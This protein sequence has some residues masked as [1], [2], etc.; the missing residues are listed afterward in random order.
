[1]FSSRSFFAAA[2]SAA[3][4]A[5]G[6]FGTS[7]AW[8]ACAAVEGRGIGPSQDHAGFLARQ[9]ATARAYQGGAAG[10][11]I[12][13]SQPACFFLDDGTNN[14]SCQVQASWCTTPVAAPR[15][16]V[17]IQPVEPHPP[18]RIDPIFRIQPHF[19]RFRKGCRKFTAEASDHTVDGAQALVYH[20]LDNALRRRTGRSLQSR[21][22]RAY[23][24]GCYRLGGHY[25][26]SVIIQCRM[27]AKV[28]G[29]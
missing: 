1:M 16:P 29:W 14:V 11:Q 22:V 10:A 3:L 2:V 28:C 6:S 8:A 27:T 13:Y 9:D 15:P 5:I 20:T 25:A 26:R 18:R 17:R 4:V 7:S 24:P 19:P 23:Q 12:Q 21:G